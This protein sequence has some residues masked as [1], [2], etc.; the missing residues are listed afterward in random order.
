MQGVKEN[1]RLDKKF[2][3]KRVW[4]IANPFPIE[5]SKLLCLLKVLSI[6]TMQCGYKSRLKSEVKTPL[7]ENQI[8]D[9]T[10]KA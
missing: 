10:I 9:K 5:R 8:V 2:I 1:V 7:E 4:P 3:D 6:D